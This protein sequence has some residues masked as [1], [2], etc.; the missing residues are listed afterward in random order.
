LVKGGVPADRVAVV[1]SGVDVGQFA[2]RSPDESLAAALLLPRNL[3]VIGNLT[4]FSWWKGQA[5]FLKAARILLDRGVKAHFL[6]V[7]K[8]TDG[9][10]ARALVKSLGLENRV[11]LAGFRRDIPNVLSLLSLSVVSS[12][13]GEGFSGVLRESMSMGI[14]VAAT[15]V[16]GNR[17]LVIPGETGRLAAPG[18]AEA[19]AEAMEKSIQDPESTRRMARAAQENVRKN[20]SLDKMVEE[21]IAL[22]ESVLAP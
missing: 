16:G 2:P 15:D 6:L 8:D 4:H 17:E 22:Y 9:A 20:Y 7:G 13:A 11:T 14:P 21:T 18:N 1:H 19:L 12:L 3:P 5:T 10:E